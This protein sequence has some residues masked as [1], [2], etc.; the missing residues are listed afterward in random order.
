MI[1]LGALAVVVMLFA[2]R[3]LWGFLADR[4]DLQFFPLARRVGLLDGPR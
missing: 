4:Y 3:G 1:L 2:R